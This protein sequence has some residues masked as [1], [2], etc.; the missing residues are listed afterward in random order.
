M[1][2]MSCRFHYIV[3]QMMK[4]IPN[5]SSQN[6]VFFN[7]QNTPSRHAE[8]TLAVFFLKIYRTRGTVA[9][10]IKILLMSG[11]FF[12]CIKIVK[13]GFFEKVYYG[14]YKFSVSQFSPK[15]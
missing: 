1:Q 5:A 9:F 4:K 3:M 8:K 15:M 2:I 11:F 12:F 10:L 14:F 7:V 13:A 6:I